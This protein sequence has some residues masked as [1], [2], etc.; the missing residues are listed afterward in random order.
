[1]AARNEPPSQLT[2]SDCPS[3]PDWPAIDDDFRTMVHHFTLP[4]PAES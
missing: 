4:L 3:P 2:V 1:M